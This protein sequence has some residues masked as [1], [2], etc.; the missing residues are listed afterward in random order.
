MNTLDLPENDDCD[1]RARTL[2][3][4][5]YLGCDFG[6]GFPLHLGNSAHAQIWRAVMGGTKEEHEAMLRNEAAIA[7]RMSAHGFDKKIYAARK[8]GEARRQRARKHKITEVTFSD[9]YVCPRHISASEFVNLYSAVAYV[10]SK[11]VAFNVHLTI[12]WKEMGFDVGDAAT[13][14]SELNRS[15]IKHFTEWC[16]SKNFEC[17]W[18]FSNEFSSRVGLHTHFMTMI[19]DDALESFRRFVALRFEKI[20]R[21]TDLSKTAF[22]IRFSRKQ[23][24]RRQWIQFQY[25][26]K[27]INP[28]E[29]LLHANGYDHIFAAD[30]IRFGYE[31]PGAIRCKRSGVSRNIDKRARR[32]EDYESLME[33]GLLNV[34][35]L[36]PETFPAKSED[37]CDVLAALSI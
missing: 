26:C 4:N 11:G 6:Q 3:E 27:G 25:L 31:N 20:S 2:I 18:L 22:E 15:F 30:L 29:R 35:L 12:C 24:L 32:N 23:V 14:A 1:D 16:R 28:Y 13:A 9:P 10:N 17:V 36:Y 33:Q 8:R 7:D 37:A 5:G 34:N 21:K 19:D